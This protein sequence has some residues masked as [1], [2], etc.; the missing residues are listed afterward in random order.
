VNLKVVRENSPIM[1]KVRDNVF[2]LAVCYGMCCDVYKM[3]G[4][5]T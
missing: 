4:D 3:N 1:K 2:S 5:F